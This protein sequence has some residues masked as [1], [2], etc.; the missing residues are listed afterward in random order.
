MLYR[1]RELTGVGS[2]WKHGPRAMQWGITGMN[3]LTFLKTVWPHMWSEYK[4]E[5][6]L[7]VLAEFDEFPQIEMVR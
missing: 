2:I 6:A 1:L 7:A 5:Q 3:A 4:K